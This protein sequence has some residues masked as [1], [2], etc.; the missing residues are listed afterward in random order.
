M[1]YNGFVSGYSIVVIRDLPKVKRRVR[2]PLPAPL[3]MSINYFCSVMEYFRGGEVLQQAWQKFR[4]HFVFAFMVFGVFVVFQIIFGVVDEWTKEMVLWSVLSSLIGFLVT[5]VMSIGFVQLF[6]N[7]I[8]TD[9]EG[10]LSALFLFQKNLF[11]ICS[12]WALASC[13]LFPA[14]TLC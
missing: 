12:L 9:T 8:D 13:S 10:K 14:Y 6:L 7:L 5:I 2:F 3:K 1:L 11:C 4:A